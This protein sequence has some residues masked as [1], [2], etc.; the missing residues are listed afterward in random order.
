M[1]FKLIFTAIYQHSCRAKADYRLPQRIRG[2][3]AILLACALLSFGQTPTAQLTGAI[4]DPS[5]AAVPGA[6]VLVVNVDTGV[7]RNT[8]SNEEGYYTVPLLPPG[9]YR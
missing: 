3:V 9:N 8:T 4:K 2:A 6:D 7:Q 5:G 1:S